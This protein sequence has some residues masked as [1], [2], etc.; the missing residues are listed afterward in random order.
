[1]L[2]RRIAIPAEPNM[3]R[4]IEGSGLLVKVVAGAHPGQRIWFQNPTGTSSTLGAD[5]L[6]LVN[7][8]TYFPRG[9]ANTDRFTEFWVT[10]EVLQGPGN[11]ASGNGQENLILEI[12]DCAT[13]VVVLNDGAG[14]GSRFHLITQQTTVATLVPGEGIDATILYADNA[15][16]EGS[17][18]SSSKLASWWPRAF[19]GG[20]VYADAAFQAVIHQHLDPDGAHRVE[21]ARFTCDT[22][23]WTTPSGTHWGFGVS[24]ETQGDP[25]ATNSATAAKPVGYLGLLPY[26]MFGISVLILPID[27]IETYGITLYARDF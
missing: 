20:G 5:G 6:P 11:T 18:P 21:M 1:M 27:Q 17:I 23:T 19:I 3:S 8:E 25:G 24:F 12:Y 2:E 9:N 14:R 10:G 22:E 15:I 7:G 13:P 16:G 26:P 4:R